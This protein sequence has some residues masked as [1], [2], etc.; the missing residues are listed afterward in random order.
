MSYDEDEVAENFANTQLLWKT[1]ITD[2]NGDPEDVW[3]N[4]ILGNSDVMDL[5]LDDQTLSYGGSTV[6]IQDH[7]ASF[8][9]LGSYDDYLA[10]ISLI[11]PVLGAWGI[12]AGNGTVWAAIDHNSAFAV[13]IP[14]P[15][16][17]FLLLVGLCSIGLQRKRRS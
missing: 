13:G 15:E 1:E 17:A 4:A 2:G 7:L 8:R 9:Y 5:N 16:S 12:D 14:Q 10:D 6:P 11:D 3:V